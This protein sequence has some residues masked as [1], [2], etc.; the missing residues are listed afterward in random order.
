MSGTVETFDTAGFRT[1][2]LAKFPSGF[3]TLISSDTLYYKPEETYDALATTIRT[4]AAPN[5]TVILAYM[6]RHGHEHGFVDLLVSGGTV[7]S[8]NNNLVDGGSVASGGSAA[9]QDA[10]GSAP[11]EEAEGE[12]AVPRFEVVSRNAADLASQTAASHA[13]RV[14]E[15]RRR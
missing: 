6:V 14:V 8:N 3:D 10:E 7:A 2:L 5:A 13:T 9:Q 11:E 4:L 15:L 12:R 1:A